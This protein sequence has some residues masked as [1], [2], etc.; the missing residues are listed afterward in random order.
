MAKRLSET[1]YAKINLALHVRARRDD[2]YHELETIFAFLDDGDVL[3]AEAAN[4]LM[5]DIT[6]PF[7]GNLEIDGNLVLQAAT[8]LRDHTGVDAGAKF[9]LDKKLPIASGIGGGSADAAAALRLLNRLWALDLTE[10]ELVDIGAPL[11]ADIA[12]CI[13]SRTCIGSGIGEQI[14]FTQDAGLADLH[15][16]L[17]NP[18][19]A[20]ATGPVF[21][22]WDGI[23][24]G[25][26]Q[27]ADILTAALAGRNDMQ[28]SA[29]K[30][31]PE[32]AG[33][34]QMLE[35]WSPLLARMSG[36]GATCF[37]L[38]DSADNM[39]DAAQDIRKQSPGYWTMTGRL[40]DAAHG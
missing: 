8:A 19:I 14:V 28:V 4:T 17:V 3:T 13:Y 34:L 12:A 30:I 22:G 24:L 25:G 2:G 40:R 23:D 32:I 10:N 5:L 33:I 37:A 18:G 6:G 31:V 29:L 21:Q 39:H 1:A 11:G 20:V 9:V 26:L 16:L 36:S 15:C 7:S 38:F 35:S 27:D